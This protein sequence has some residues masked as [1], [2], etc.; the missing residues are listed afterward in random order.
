M[1]KRKT[2]KKGDEQLWKQ[3][4]VRYGLTDLQIFKAKE[5]KLNPG[6]FEKYAGNKSQPWKS[7][8]GSFIDRIYSKEFKNQKPTIKIRSKEQILFDDVEELIKQGFR[9]YIKESL[10]QDYKKSGIIG[11]I[12]NKCIVPSVLTKKCRGK[13]KLF[14]LDNSEVLLIAKGKS[15]ELLNQP[16]FT[17]KPVNLEFIPL[18]IGDIQFSSSKPWRTKLRS[19][20]SS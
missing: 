11:K 10:P 14:L 12:Q 15:K 19:E 18:E 2:G 17:S 13:C 16:F 6:K 5:L 7:S 1:T 3:S 8:L 4:Q 9:W 20:E